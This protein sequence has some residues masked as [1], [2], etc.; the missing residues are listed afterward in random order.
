MNHIPVA[1]GIAD[2][3]ERLALMEAVS[4]EDFDFAP[5]F[6]EPVDPEPW[7]HWESGDEE[8]RAIAGEKR[9]LLVSGAAG[10]LATLT[11]RDI[12]CVRAPHADGELASLVQA[13]HVFSE[14][15]VR[16]LRVCLLYRTGASGL[17]PLRLKVAGAHGI[18]WQ[19]PRCEPPMFS[20]VVFSDRWQAGV[21]AHAA[22]V[23]SRFM[24]TLPPWMQG[25]VTC[26]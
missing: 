26:H 25:A 18:E 22:E 12:A 4:F 1:V 21:P 6:N 2:V 5:F 16:G 20:G 23:V 7:E 24:S 3:F 15:A 13:S 10:L 14:L 11:E 17:L 8:F 9:L 19:A